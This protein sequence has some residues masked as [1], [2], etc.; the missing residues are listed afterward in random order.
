MKK[1]VRLTESD[2]IRLVKRIIK[3]EKKNPIRELVQTLQDRAFIKDSSNEN[4]SVTYTDPILSEF[5]GPV[6]YKKN[7]ESRLG[8]KAEVK[9]FLS[10]K[11][12]LVVNDTMD[13]GMKTYK[14]PSEYDRFIS[15]M[16]TK[17]Y[18]KNKYG[19]K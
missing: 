8:G 1:V 2:L 17:Q 3:E 5:N 16:S 11:N 19:N 18:W 14:F 7:Y 10:D 12:I 4:R 9:V 15:D 6:S 13:G